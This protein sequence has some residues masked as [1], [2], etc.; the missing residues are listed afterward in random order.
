MNTLQKTFV[1]RAMI[2]MVALAIIG[3]AGV[4]AYTQMTQSNDPP[5]KLQTDVKTKDIIIKS[6]RD[7]TNAESEL[8]SIK[9]EDEKE[10]ESLEQ[11]GNGL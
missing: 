2:I 8:E 1:V 9:L 11:L 10:G 3:A 5:T 7:L 6:E 4:F